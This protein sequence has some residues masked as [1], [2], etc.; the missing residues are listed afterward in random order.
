MLSK[1][2][3]P[4]V[5]HRKKHKTK[6]SVEQIEI[7]N[8]EFN[9]ENDNNNNIVEFKDDEEVEDT[10]N[11]KNI[12][13]VRSLI[14]PTEEDIKKEEENENN[15]NNNT[16]NNK[17]ENNNSENNN[18]ENN[19]NE[20]NNNENNENENNENEK[21]DNNEFEIK[22]TEEVEENLKYNPEPF[23]TPDM[24]KGKI[25]PYSKMQKAIESYNK[26]KKQ[27]NKIIL[28]NPPESYAE[29]SKKIGIMLDN[30][31]KLNDILTII[32]ENGRIFSNKKLRNNE[33]KNKK[34]DKKIDI[35][36]ELKR[37]NKSIEESN[38]K[39][40][41]MYKNEYE[42]IKERLEQ[43]TSDNYVE[44]KKKAIEELNEQIDLLEKDNKSLKRD[45]QISESLLKKEIK[46]NSVANHIKEKMVECERYNNIYNN[47]LKKI[48]NG[49][50][51]EKDNEIII[52]N[53]QERESKLES[54]AKEMYGIYVFE[55]V[56]NLEKKELK[57]KYDLEKIK[58]QIEIIDKALLSNKKK[59]ENEYRINEYYI[60]NLHSSKEELLTIFKEK[61]DKLEKCEKEIK[62]I[63]EE[64]EK[65][66]F[67]DEN[68]NISEI[69][70]DEDNKNSEK[71][72]I[73]I[74]KKDNSEK[75]MILKEL[76]K[77]QKEEEL[78]HEKNEKMN[79][80]IVLK[81]ISLKPNFSF[82]PGLMTDDSKL[83]K[84]LNI[85]QNYVK[86]NLDNDEIIEDII[87]DNNNK[88]E[89]KKKE[90]NRIEEESNSKKSEL[91]PE[92]LQPITIDKNNQG[93]VLENLRSQVLNTAVINNDDLIN[94]DLEHLESNTGKNEESDTN[95]HEHIFN[96]ISQ[97]IDFNQIKKNDE[98][99]INN[100]ENDI[101]D[102]NTNKSNNNDDNNTN[103]S[104]NN[105]DNNINK[106]N[107]N[108]NN[109]NEDNNKEDLN[110]M[111]NEEKSVKKAGDYSNGDEDSAIV[112][113][114]L[115]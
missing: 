108:S 80:S 20:N 57:K 41:N 75:E 24:K 112:E 38:K 71:E 109:N 68:I 30:M 87:V 103:K 78:I 15:E 2:N 88:D 19:N 111:E 64:I 102:N 98:E 91:K 59:Y 4:K 47:L 51:V 39:V 69:N 28:K 86:D 65:L 76:E 36:E 8:E 45:Q 48:E 92:T 35:I 82:T 5:G 6:S 58:K 74:I 13:Q 46:G 32:I 101:N 96:D 42:K 107:N 79:K 61:K 25:V 83:N 97:K 29:T 50:Q 99:Q 53:L 43:V 73:K 1:N 40:I 93:N 114:M 22:K 106:S 115:K 110:Y 66:N 44:N 10:N 100:N 104:N 14:S 11:V 89:D 84:S 33:N 85:R 3:L 52:K 26:I 21:N 94:K 113:E 54:M 105:D 77:K 31:N 56:K 27:I 70:I 34:N 18:N 55:N 90:E 60:Q 9:S 95:E 81:N 23:L 37:K 17:T 12:N 63:E 67:L 72:P 49:I 7:K 62:F 16:E